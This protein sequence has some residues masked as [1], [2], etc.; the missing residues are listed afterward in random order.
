[1]H[2]EHLELNIFGLGAL[3]ANKTIVFYPALCSIQT[4]ERVP[5]S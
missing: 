2:V 3:S 5:P 1:M 4:K